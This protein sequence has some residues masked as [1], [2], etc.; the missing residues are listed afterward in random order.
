M[1][2]IDDK[3]YLHIKDLETSIN[4]MGFNI[5]RLCEIKD[6]STA[7][8]SNNNEVGI[9]TLKCVDSDKEYRVMTNDRMWKMTDANQLIDII[10][11][12]VSLD[13][14]TKEQIIEKIYE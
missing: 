9:Y 14:Q 8:D 3:V 5:D 10:K 12:S 4:R 2:K 7:K 11:A 6:I 1:L 13:E